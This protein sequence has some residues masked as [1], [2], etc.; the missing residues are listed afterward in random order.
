MVVIP[1]E[2]Q[3]NEG[4][5]MIVKWFGVLAAVVLLVPCPA[6]AQ[7]LV[8]AAT[9]AKDLTFPAVA[10]TVSAND[11]RM[12]LTGIKCGQNVTDLA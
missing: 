5:D 6:A 3:V 2:R 12:T 10:A 4:V 1:G 11:P 8:G 9:Q 7:G